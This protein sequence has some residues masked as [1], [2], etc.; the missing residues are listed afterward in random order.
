MVLT[1]TMVRWLES[2]P[3]GA[4]IG[5]IPVGDG[6]AGLRA[7]ARHE[8]RDVRAARCTKILA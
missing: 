2:D 5:H 8:P 1:G 6:C 4:D 7:E 3:I